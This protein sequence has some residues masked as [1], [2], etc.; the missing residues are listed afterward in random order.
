MTINPQKIP[1]AIKMEF[2]CPKSNKRPRFALI[3]GAYRLGSV[4]WEEAIFVIAGEKGRV[5]DKISQGR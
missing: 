1:K 3:K 4:F 5:R 2:V